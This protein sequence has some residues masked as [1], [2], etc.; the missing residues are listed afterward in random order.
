M[1]PSLSKQVRH[2]QSY[3]T[4]F[5]GCRY[6]RDMVEAFRPVSGRIEISGLRKPREGEPTNRQWLKD[7]LGARIRPQW[8]TGPRGWDGHWA[9]ARAHFRDVVDALAVRVGQVRVE[10]DFNIH[11]QC[12]TRCQAATGDDCTC[13][14]LGQNHGALTGGGAYGAWVAVG[15]TTLVSSTV[16]RLSFTR[17]RRDV[18]R[19]RN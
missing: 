3:N 15:E 16:E 6:C 9:V 12:D 5:R 4:F 10:V 2:S 1:I 11:E 13:S 17:T 18:E 14:C 19:A 8:V 7:T